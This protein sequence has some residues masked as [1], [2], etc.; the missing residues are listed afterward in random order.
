[1]EAFAWLGEL[2]HWFALWVP[3][4][5]ICRATHGGVKFVHGK[6]VKPI[7]AGLYMYWP[8]VTEVEIIPVAQQAIDLPSQ[9]LTT[10]DNKTVLVS[11]VL[12]YEVEDTVKGCAGTYDLD[13]TV[14]D[15]GSTAAVYAI[16]SR[17]FAEV[18]LELTEDVKKELKRR[19]LLLLRP[20]GIR[21]IDA[22]F[23]EFCE[24]RVIVGGGSVVPLDDDE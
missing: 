7:R 8:L 17:T 19:S 6:R 15:V 1:V 9:K 22:R 24:C 14:S 10:K 12:V 5:K 2:I 20:F 13:Q 4:L 21:V 18:Q 3:R 16:T 23:S 11:S